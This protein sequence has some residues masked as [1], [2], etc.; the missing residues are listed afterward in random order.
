[1]G[2]VSKLLQSILVPWM[3]SDENFLDISWIDPE[4]RTERRALY[5]VQ[6]KRLSRIMSRVTRLLSSCGALDTLA[7]RGLD[8]FSWPRNSS[9]GAKIEA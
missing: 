5:S 6:C 1:M 2:L 3:D 4:L 7:A 9:F 8:G